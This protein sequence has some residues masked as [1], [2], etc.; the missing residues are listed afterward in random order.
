[1][2]DRLLL[3]VLIIGVGFAAY[4]ALRQWDL[5]RARTR[6]DHQDPI[7]EP[8]RIGQ[9]AI[10]YFTADWC[11]ACKAQQQPALD[12]LRAM[13][14]DVAIIQVDVEKEPDAAER[15]GVMSLP[16][17]YVLNHHGQATAVNYG[18]ASASKLKQQLEG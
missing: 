14:D 12:K 7:T 6:I 11:M 16:T 5:Y 3:T 9:P 13:V 1:M 10:L 15:W 17:T 18:V 2:A 4:G 8:I